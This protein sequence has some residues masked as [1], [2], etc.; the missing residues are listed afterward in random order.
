MQSGIAN[1]GRVLTVAEVKEREGMHK[2]LHYIQ[3]V[4]NQKHLH[5]RPYP[6]TTRFP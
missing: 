5:R 6:Q 2:H 3:L 4:L 1:V